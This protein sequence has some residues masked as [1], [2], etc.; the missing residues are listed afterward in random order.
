MR[1]PE[2]GRMRVLTVTAAGAERLC[3]HMGAVAEPVREVLGEL[4]AVEAEL[5]SGVLE[6]LAARREEAAATTPGP[7]RVYP[8][9]GHS[10]A[11]LM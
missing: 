9:D 8:A 3:E 10:R 6:R 11:L 2:D 1:H 7:E 5:V 4:P